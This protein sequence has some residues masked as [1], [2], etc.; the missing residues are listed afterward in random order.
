MNRKVDGLVQRNDE[1]RE[2][3]R[4]HERKGKEGEVVL[5]K[6]FC[7]DPMISSSSLD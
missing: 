7:L 4:N 1:E 6:V 2:G 3:G 5:V